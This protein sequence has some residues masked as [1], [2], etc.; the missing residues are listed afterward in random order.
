MS[1]V[2]TLPAPA[3]PRVEPPENYLSE[4]TVSSWLLTTD[5][6]RIGILY[7]FSILVYFAIAA[8]GGGDDA[9]RAA[10]AARATWSFR[11]LTISSS[12]STAC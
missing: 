12:Q 1:P 8:V 5:H 6:K 10:I 3:A 9:D 11:R 2:E 4:H 7:L